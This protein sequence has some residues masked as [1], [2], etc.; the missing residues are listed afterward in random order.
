[1]PAVLA[2]ILLGAAAAASWAAQTARAAPPLSFALSTW[3]VGVENFDQSVCGVRQWAQFLPVEWTIVL[4]HQGLVPEMLDAVRDEVKDKKHRMLDVPSLQRRLE[5]SHPTRSLLY[6]RSELEVL[7]RKLLTWTLVE[8]DCIFSVDTDIFIVRTPFALL[9]RSIID[10]TSDPNNIAGTTA[11]LPFFNGGLL[12]FK[13]DMGV[14]RRLVTMSGGTSIRRTCEPVVSDQSLLNYAFSARWKNLKSLAHHTHHLD[15]KSTCEAAIVHFVGPAK[16]FVWVAS[17]AR[18]RTAMRLGPPRMLGP[19]RND[20]AKSTCEAAIVHFVGPAKPFV[21]VA[22]C[23]RNRTEMRLGPP[24][25]LG[26]PRN[27]SALDLCEKR[28]RIESRT[29][30]FLFEHRKTPKRTRRAGR[31]K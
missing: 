9:D 16:P 18:N 2:A 7:R 26:P 31:E 27:D 4:I 10:F 28:R 3:I 30:R 11:C 20:S 19:P 15:Y 5:P 1:M 8:Y 17:C 25:M 29:E 22:S 24:R 21:W 23:A 13:S 12:F 6:L 14:T